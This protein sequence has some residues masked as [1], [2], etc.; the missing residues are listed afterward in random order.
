MENSINKLIDE[1]LETNSSKI[2]FSKILWKSRMKNFIKNQ[3]NHFKD[4]WEVLEKEFMVT[5]EILGL[6]FKGVIDR[7]DIN[8]NKIIILDYKTGNVEKINRDILD[9]QMNIYWNILKKKIY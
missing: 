2:K 5:G 1:L 6:K 7:I 8:D 4:G 3:I 9:F